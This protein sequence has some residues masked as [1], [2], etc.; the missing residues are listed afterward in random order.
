MKK[1]NCSISTGL[2]S[3]INLILLL[4]A[5]PIKKCENPYLQQIFQMFYFLV[6]VFVRV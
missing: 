1:K 4:Y 2:L 3:E 5:I 6:S